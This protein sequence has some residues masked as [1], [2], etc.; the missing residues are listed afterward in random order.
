MGS[1]NQPGVHPATQQKKTAVSDGREEAIRVFSLAGLPTARVSLD[2]GSQRAIR[3]WPKESKTS[4][5]ILG[6]GMARRLEAEGFK[7][8]PSRP[9]PRGGTETIYLK[10]TVGVTVTETLTEVEVAVSGVLRP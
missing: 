4:A 1:I 5:Y 6:G 3:S 8:L 10:G 9:H 2:W 7:A